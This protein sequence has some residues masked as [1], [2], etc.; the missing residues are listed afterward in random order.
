MP[1]ALFAATVAVTTVGVAAGWV[2]VGYGAHWRTTSE[3]RP[4]LRDYVSAFG[5]EVMATLRTWMGYATGMSAVPPFSPI[6]DGGGPPIALIHGYMMNRSSMAWLGR[7]LRARGFANVTSL[8]ARPHRASMEVQAE[9]LANDLRRWSAHAGGAKIIVV[10]HSQGGLL[11]RVAL[12]KYPDLPIA[13]VVTIGSPHAGTV[14]AQMARA[15]N[16]KQMRYGSEFL[17]DLP[18]PSVPFVSIY[19]NLDNIVFPKETSLFGRSIE[20]P[21][22]GHHAL[23][24]SPEVL[25]ATVEAFADFRLS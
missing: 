22:I 10:A 20:L 3:N 7:G 16:A 13:G 14:L 23:C 9:A 24:F 8:E 25:S 6:V 1:I 5:P 17:R 12:A 15:P 2:A 18:R 11:T 4:K 19:S 21:G